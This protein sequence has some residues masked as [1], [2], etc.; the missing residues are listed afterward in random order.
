MG[1]KPC[2]TPTETAEK[3]GLI[4]LRRSKL[5]HTRLNMYHSHRPIHLRHVKP[6]RWP[7]LFTPNYIRLSTRPTGWSLLLIGPPN[8]TGGQR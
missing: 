3:G 1:S 4:S 7:V 6:Y 2:P 5:P 8:P